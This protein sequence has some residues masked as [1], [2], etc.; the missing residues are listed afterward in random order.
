MKLYLI[1]AFVGAAL[2]S[3]DNNTAQ[4]PVFQSLNGDNQ[5]INTEAQ[6]KAPAGRSSQVIPKAF[7]G[8]WVPFDA[9]AAE[10]YEKAE[11]SIDQDSMD[12][13]LI[14]SKVLE[15]VIISESKVWLK[16]KAVGNDTWDDYRIL[17]LSNN[18]QSLTVNQVTA[19]GKI[20]QEA[21]A[22]EHWKRAK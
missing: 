5:T 1:I 20:V 10:Y 15:L 2:A 6:K 11:L 7:H 9:A 21:D 8:K 4:G 18:G 12:S 22:K 19:D 14:V 3:C 16:R 13:D 17:E